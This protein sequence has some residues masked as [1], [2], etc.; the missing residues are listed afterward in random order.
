LQSASDESR[1]LVA[2]EAPH[3]ICD[4]LDDISEVMGN[5]SVCVARE[6]TKMFEEFF[7]G[8]VAQAR[9]HF[10]EHAPRGE[11]TLVIAGKSQAEASAEAQAAWND[12]RVRTRVSGLMLSGMTRTEAVKQ[13]ARESGRERRAVYALTLGE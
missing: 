7:R 5:R 9:A 4:S 2:Y 8:N 13:T 1:T 11:F 10:A 3:R 12:D 6:L